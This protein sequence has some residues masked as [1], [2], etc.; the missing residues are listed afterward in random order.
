[1]LYSLGEISR[2]LIRQSDSGSSLHNII[3][4]IT[5]WSTVGAAH[6]LRLHSFTPLG[7]GQGVTI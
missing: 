7:G 5:K 4:Y 3:S 2:V 6:C 1:M